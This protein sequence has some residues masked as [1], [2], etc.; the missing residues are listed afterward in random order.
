MSSI[1]SPLVGG[2]AALASA[3][4]SLL[5]VD[6]A[7]TVAQGNSSAGSSTSAG[8]GVPGLGTAPLGSGTLNTI[9][10]GGSPIGDLLNSSGFGGVFGGS[11]GGVMPGQQSGSTF[12][13]VVS[14]V[15]GLILIGGGIIMFRPEI[16]EAARDAV[17]AG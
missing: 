5:P 9:L 14:V 1:Y 3:E 13:R 8:D 16:G 10:S 11:N 15:L 7:A 2:E 6:Y 17:I 4:Q 12:S